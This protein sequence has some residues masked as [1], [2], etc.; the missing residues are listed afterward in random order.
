[1]S[2]R[3]AART[4]KAL[5]VA[6]SSLVTRRS[7]RSVTV[8]NIIDAADVGRSTFYEHFARKDDLLRACFAPLRE[9]LAET[10]GRAN[11]S[12]SA[13]RPVF[14][15]AVFDHADANRAMYRAL[16]G[17][18]GC[19]VAHEEVAAIIIPS[20]RRHITDRPAAA[21]LPPDVRER[22]VLA[23]FAT[24]LSW[25]LTERPQLTPAETDDVFWQFVTAGV[26]GAP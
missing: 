8:Q 2:D 21:G 12:A 20:V 3:R 26:G 11:A 24:V 1:M 22:L 25:W 4:R 19:A 10:E 17:G 16:M 7:Y 23:S 5:V 9:K 18:A 6:M 14:S 13:C 15:R